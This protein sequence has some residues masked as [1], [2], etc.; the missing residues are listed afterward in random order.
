MKYIAVFDIP[1]D[2]TIGCAAAKVAKKGKKEYTNTDFTNV[3]ADVE[4]LVNEKAEVFERFNTVERVLRDV[5]ISCA[6]DMPSFWSNNR[7]KYHVIATKY[8]KG[9][10]QALDDIEKEIRRRFGF[11]EKEDMI[12]SPYTAVFMEEKQ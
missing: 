10:M 4:P 9:Y 3:Y 11:A 6:Y 5:G 7:E 2:C 8:H 1:D 12:L